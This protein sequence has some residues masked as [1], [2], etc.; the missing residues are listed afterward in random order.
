MYARPSARFLTVLLPFLALAAG[1]APRPVAAPTARPAAYDPAADTLRFAGEVH[2][3]NVRQLT[4]GG[5]NAEAYWSFD[6]RQLVFQS[7]WGR[8]N[9][10]GCDQ[11]YVMNADGSPVLNARTT[12]AEPPAVTGDRYRIVSTGRGRTTCGYFLPDGRLVFASTHA[13]G[14]ACPPPAAFQGGRYVWAIYDT[15]DI[16]TTAADGTDLRPL[17]Q[18]PGYDAEATV[19]PDGRY[20]VFTSTRSGDLDLW[21]LDRQTGALLQLTNTPGYDGGAFF[22]RDSKQLVWRAS[23]PA[24]ADLEA[25]QTL[26]RQGFVEPKAMQLFVANADGSNARQVTDLPGANWAPFFHP[27]GRQIL[28]ASNHETLAQGGRSFSIYTIG[29]DGSGLRKVV[30]S[31]TFD[32]FPMFSFDGTKLVFASNRNRARTPSRDTNIFVADW[33]ETPTPADLNFGR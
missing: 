28:F 27:S 24:G 2:L 3:R 25:Y 11:Q 15:Y 30:S 9:G 1:C 16:Y 33:V 22:S 4:F 10:Q 14:P 18:N 13:A 12:G 29:T 31:G 8:I 23:R 5:N 21:R 19:S 17:V 7:D 20:V 32:A 6:D 26:L